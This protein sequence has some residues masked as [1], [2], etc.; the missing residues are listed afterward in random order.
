[1]T[2]RRVVI[3][4]GHK[5]VWLSGLT[6]MPEFSVGSI[7]VVLGE[8][9]AVESFDA[10]VVVL[11]SSGK[12]VLVRDE[13][14]A[15]EFPGGHREGDESYGETAVREAYEEAGARIVEV[16]YL[17]Y[18]V[19]AGGQVT[20]ITCA[21]AASFEGAGDG[22]QAPGVG[23][24]D[25]LPPFLSFGDGRESL[26]LDYALAAR[27]GPRTQADGASTCLGQSEIQLS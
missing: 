6:R 19:T 7:Q 3:L 25:R 21:K 8:T 22:G 10:V 11:F 4:A 15:W 12:L 20:V 23:L 13:R 1:L 5:E 16:Q 9:P 14:R 18:Y 26:F 17:G 2:E 24:F 27:S